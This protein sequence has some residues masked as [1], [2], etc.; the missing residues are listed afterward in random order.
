MLGTAPIFGGGVLYGASILHHVATKPSPARRLVVPATCLFGLLLILVLASM[1]WGA[2]TLKVY[3]ILGPISLAAGFLLRY[4]VGKLTASQ[5]Y[6]SQK[7]MDQLERMDAVQDDWQQSWE[8]HGLTV[9]VAFCLL[10][11]ILAFKLHSD[12]LFAMPG[13]SSEIHFWHYFGLIYPALLLG[14]PALRKAVRD[15]SKGYFFL[16]AFVLSSAFL[17]SVVGFITSLLKS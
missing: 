17:V 11:M 5:Y 1:I 14:V 2:E 7:T 13:E 15:W 8:R 6:L 4:G 3:L 12:D 10:S 9:L 16:L